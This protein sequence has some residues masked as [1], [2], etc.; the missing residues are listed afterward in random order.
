MGKGEA[1]RTFELGLQCLLELGKLDVF[2]GREDI[3][4]HYGFLVG[5]DGTFVCATHE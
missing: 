1:K 4:G 2:E 5:T 3:G